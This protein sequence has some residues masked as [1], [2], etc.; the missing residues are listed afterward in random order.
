MS[1]EKSPR[2]AAICAALKS[3]LA[4]RL[5]QKLLKTQGADAASELKRK[6]LKDDFQLESLLDNIASC[7][8]QIQLATHILKGI[9]PSI[10]VKEATNLNV[11]PSTLQK[12]G[13]V[14]SHI[15]A[16]DLHPDATGNGSYVTRVYEVSVLLQTKF[17]GATVLDLIKAGDQDAIAAL[18]ASAKEASTNAQAL[19]GID[20][21]RCTRTASEAR[22]K[23]LYWL[24]GTDAHDDSAFHL[25][26][27]L[28]PTSLVH[29]V[30]QQLQ[31]DRF[32]DE[33]K[34][35]RA[36][37]KD[38]SHHPRPVHEYSD[39]AIQQLGGTKP[40]NISQ[41]NSERRG[42]NCL[43][44]SV[45]PVWKSADVRPLL[46]VSS[47]FK[48]FGRRR[49]VQQQARA[50]RRFLEAKPVANVET[51]RKVDAWVN[52]LIDELLQFSAELQT[53]APGWTDSSDCTL[54][55]AQRLWLDPNDAEPITAAAVA[56]DAADQVAEDF[57]RWLNTQLRDP[58]PVGDAEFLHW[59]KLAREQ[60][61]ADERESA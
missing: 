42:N 51:R 59:R 17:E 18:G 2:S 5:R 53:L 34:A 50:M 8:G 39:L 26:A 19:A 4:T 55:A 61:S 3:H 13:A 56:D 16:D 60:F 23:Q 29:R 49:D 32:S 47:L 30:Y 58:L 33:A 21:A 12:H 40:Q 24:V 31:D 41:L 28:Y 48:V 52:G 46:G 44:A 35:A 36:A 1:L 20:D 14:G 25:L 38:G 27:P 37:R 11:V 15:L 9:H 57:A 6:K 22:A 54:P 10:K 45:P 43:L 7:V